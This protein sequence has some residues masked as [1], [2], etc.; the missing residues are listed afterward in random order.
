[1]NYPEQD[2]WTRSVT[3]M[4]E[5]YFN[6]CNNFFC[7]SRIFE[8]ITITLLLDT[9]FEFM[10]FTRLKWVKQTRKDTVSRLTCFKI[11]TDI[12]VIVSFEAHVFFLTG[13]HL[14]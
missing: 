14:I 10:R 7:F 1:M 8:Q 12:K 11:P 6:R 4:R 5:L 9:W 13:V 2:Y 3:L